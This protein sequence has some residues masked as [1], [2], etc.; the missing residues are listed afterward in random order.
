MTM[1]NKILLYFLLT[2]FSASI[3]ETSAQVGLQISPNLRLETQKGLSY[4]NTGAEISILDNRDPQVSGKAGIRIS[5]NNLM[6]QS[7]LG[8][9]NCGFCPS[10][11][12]YWEYGDIYEVKIN[13]GGP[14]HLLI[15]AEHLFVQR[16]YF[17]L[18]SG[19][20]FLH[21]KF[22]VSL[23]YIT[24]PVFNESYL[25]IGFLT[26]LFFKEITQKR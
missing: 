23:N 9:Y 13:L 16:D 2:F 1:K 22:E 11:E 20:S 7:L 19:L 8:D 3:S 21:K 6:Y 18:G 4:L 24:H 5:R 10:P 25:R 17:T 12:S 26:P 14:F 15:I